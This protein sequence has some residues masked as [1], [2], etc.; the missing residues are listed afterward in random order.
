M[1]NEKSLKNY[2][3]GPRTEHER[4]VFAQ[5]RLHVDI[6]VHIHELMLQKNVS[7]EELQKRLVDFGYARI[8]VGTLFRDYCDLS[9]TELATVYHALG[10]SLA[11]ITKTDLDAVS[12]CLTCK[13]Q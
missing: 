4:L 2:N 5:E 8:D 9:I 13:N 6:Q 11:V 12:Q 7:R 10:E 3:F 1:E